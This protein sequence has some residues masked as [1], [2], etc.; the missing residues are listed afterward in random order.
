MVGSERKKKKK[1]GERGVFIL[2]RAP[3]ERSAG[4]MVPGSLLSQ[5]RGCR[6]ARLNARVHKE[7]QTRKNRFTHAD[8]VLPKIGAKKVE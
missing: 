5:Q 2:M 7:A 8:I 3:S 4:A 1:K 6:N